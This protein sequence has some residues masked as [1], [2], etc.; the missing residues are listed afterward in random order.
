MRTVITR[1]KLAFA[2][3]MMYLWIV[4]I[5]LGAIVFE[6]FIVYPNIFH[7]VP[8]SFQTS[9]DF[10]AVAGPSDFFPPV[11]MLAVVTGIGAV[12]LSWREKSVRYWLLASVLLLII[13]L[14]ILSVF[15]FWPRNTIMFEEGVAEHSV[16]VL[17]QTAWEFQMGHWI[18]LGT[19]IA[20]SAL[21]FIG[22]LKL[23]KRVIVSRRME[24]PA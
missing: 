11:G 22:V 16:A 8:E 18:R 4:M 5:L 13:A 24:P 23:Y 10:M 7:T 9:M 12:S 1:E 3:G 2:F 17:K 20:T 14:F 21:A 15:F 19:S 6:T